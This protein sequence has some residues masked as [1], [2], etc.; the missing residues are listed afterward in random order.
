M[1][2]KKLYLKGIPMIIWGEPSDKLYIHVHGKQ[3]KK[4]FAEGFAKI[5]EKKGY[6]TL[7]F[8]LPEHGERI[9]SGI[10][11]DIWNG[12]KEL[13]I[14]ADFAF[15]HWKEVSFFACSLGAYFSLNA[16][17]D[18]P[19]KK[20]L[21]QSPLIDMEHMIRLIFKWYN[22]TEESLEAEKEIQ[23][24][25][26][27]LQWDYFQYAINHP[28]KK[29]SIP[30]QI[31]YA[32]KDSF[33]PKEIIKSFAEANHCGLTVSKDSE[34]AFMAPEDGEIVTTWLDAYI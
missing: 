9:S 12:V 33:Q 19:F 3:S 28:I 1:L 4:E 22:V 16:Y 8:D 23:T 15:S 14:V 21:L 32:A 26:D 17:G 6:Q 29:W 24:P 20:C 10:R 7:S 5:A 31:L 11:C 25:F 13:N 2:T 34:H 30:T 18:M 27:L